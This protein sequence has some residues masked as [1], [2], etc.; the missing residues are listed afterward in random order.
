MENPNYVLSTNENIL[1]PKNEKMS[2][3]K[4]AVLVIIFVIIIGSV[5][6]QDNLFSELS[7]TAR[8]LLVAAA[9]GVFVSGEKIRVPSPIELRFYDDYLIVYRPKI[10]Y[11]RKVT[12]MEFN[13]MF[14]NEIHDCYYLKDVERI[15]IYGVM[16][17]EWSD[18]GKDGTLPPKPTIVRSMDSLLHFR[19]SAAPDV[20]FV[21]EI[22]QHSPIKV[23]IKNN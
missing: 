18:Y 14:Y 13:K 5:L 6:F 3:L 8:I 4:I 12:R 17:V 10:Y 23:T 9:I 11:N 16:H 21:A 20:D 19:T 1:V 15:K 2:A 7:W 22:E